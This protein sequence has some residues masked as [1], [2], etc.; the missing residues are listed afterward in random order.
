MIDPLKL[1]Q[2]VLKLAEAKRAYDASGAAPAGW[3]AFVELASQVVTPA[4]LDARC[5]TEPR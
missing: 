5:K 3:P 2:A 4:V 1:V